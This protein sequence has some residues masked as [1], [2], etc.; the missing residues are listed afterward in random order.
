[1]KILR[2]LLVLPVMALVSCADDSTGFTTPAVHGKV[3]AGSGG[4]HVSIPHGI[5]SN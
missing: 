1:M 2:F 4:E 5:T 3:W